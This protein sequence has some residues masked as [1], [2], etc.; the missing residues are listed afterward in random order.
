MFFIPEVKDYDATVPSQLIFA[1]VMNVRSAN[2]DN[3]QQRGVS[4]DSTQL[5]FTAE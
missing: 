2:I 3:M 4:L 1:T 5:T